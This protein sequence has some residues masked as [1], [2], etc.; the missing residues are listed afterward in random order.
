MTRFDELINQQYQWQMTPVEIAELNLLSAQKTLDD[1]IS[2]GI[3]VNPDASR[4]IEQLRKR[5]EDL[6]VNPK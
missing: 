5:Y 6:K 4:R 3:L 2:L 1:R